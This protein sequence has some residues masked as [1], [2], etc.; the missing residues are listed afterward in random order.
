[1]HIDD[2]EKRLAAIFA[3]YRDAT[4]DPNPAPDFMPQLWRRI[5]AR[6]TLPLTFKRFAQVF[7]SAALA[8]CLVMAVLMA[9]PQG[10]GISMSYIDYLDEAHH[11]AV[12]YAEVLHNELPSDTNLQ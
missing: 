3:A 6:R 2:P 9:I 7:L 12:A 11:A 5:E 1:M 4:P 8:L 10:S